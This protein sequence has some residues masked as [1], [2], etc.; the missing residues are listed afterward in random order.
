MSDTQPLAR[1]AK[2]QEALDNPLI[3]EALSAWETEI[4]DAWKKS[5]LRDVEGREKLRL[6]L[7]AANTFKTHLEAVVATGKLLKAP[8]PTPSIWHRARQTLNGG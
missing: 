3:A 5:P 1:A 6:M 2:A 8:T 4:T 7:E